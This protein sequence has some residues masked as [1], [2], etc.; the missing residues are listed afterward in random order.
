MRAPS[1]RQKPGRRADSESLCLGTVR[2][3]RGIERGT[4]RT[5][6]PNRSKTTGEGSDH[7]SQRAG[8][9][10]EAEL[11]IS[12]GLGWDE[13]RTESLVTGRPSKNVWDCNGSATAPI[14]TRFPRRRRVRQRPPARQQPRRHSNGGDARRCSPSE[15][16]SKVSK[17]EA[18]C[19]GWVGVD[20]SS[21]AHPW[22][23]GRYRTGFNFTLVA[24]GPARHTRTRAL[25]LLLLRCAAAGP[26]P[27]QS[28]R[29][30][31]HGQGK[32]ASFTA[33]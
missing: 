12:L 31:W 3:E 14:P 33:T 29:K 19:C 30:P 28:I 32:A 21:R 7:G 25:P 24:S 5:P 20:P 27:I 23:T 16:D 10:S 26:P 18:V 22:P 4:R 13:R 9:S 6:N 15:R 11:R 2:R 17:I 8:A 1:R